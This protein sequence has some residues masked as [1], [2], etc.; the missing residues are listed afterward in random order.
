MGNTPVVGGNPVGAGPTG[1]GVNMPNTGPQGA[2]F[3]L[4]RQNYQMRPTMRNPPYGG[5]GQMGPGAGG[6]MDTMASAGQFGAMGGGGGVGAGPPQQQ[7]QQQ[8]GN[9]FSGQG[10]NAGASYMMR[11]PQPGYNQQTMMNRHQQP[12]INQGMMSGGMG[13][14]GGGYNMG[15]MGNSGGAYMQSAPN[16]NMGNMQQ[17]QAYR[18]VMNMQQRQQQQ[19]QQQQQMQMRMQTPQLM[20]QLQR[21]PANMGPQQQMNYQQQQQRF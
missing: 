13:A 11:Q 15:R 21:G 20:A 19:Q 1:S 8:F 9:N 10:M 3:A 16:V 12:G 6:A 18:P 14:G 17:Q 2:P 7:Q 5:G 4:P